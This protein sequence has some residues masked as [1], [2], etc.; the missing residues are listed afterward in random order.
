MRFLGFLGFFALFVRM[1]SFPKKIK[2]LKIILIASFTYTTESKVIFTTPKNLLLIFVDPKQLKT[3][4]RRK[5]V[6]YETQCHAIGQ[7]FFYYH[8]VTY[9]I[10]C[11]VSGNLV[12]YRGC[13]VFEIAFFTLRRFLPYTPSCCFQDLP[14]TGSSTSKLAGIH[15]DLQNI[16][17]AR[18]FV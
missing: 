5:S 18:L 3:P 17:P 14:G 1:I 11:H 7:F 9:R 4:S 13:Y 8:Y 15:A 10:P 16:A 6:T 2:K 12:I